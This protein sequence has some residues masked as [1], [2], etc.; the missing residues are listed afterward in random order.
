MSSKTKEQDP[1]C[2]ISTNILP[3]N[4]TNTPFI[5]SANCIYVCPAFFDE[6]LKPK[7]KFFDLIPLRADEL[8]YK[9]VEGDKW[10]PLSGFDA[11]IW[12]SFEYDEAKF[13]YVERQ[14]KLFQCSD[15]LE[16]AGIIQELQAQEAAK[17]IKSPTH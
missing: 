4:S 1:S 5:D 14:A 3:Q 15:T 10:S 16:I 17:V 8:L 11:V 7:L 6:V 12:F 9:D 13:I 2:T